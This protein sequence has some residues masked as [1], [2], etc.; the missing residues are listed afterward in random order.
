MNTYIL[1][2]GILCIVLGLIHS[3]LG[4]YLIFKHKRNKSELVPTKGGKDLREKHLRIIWATWH[5]ASIFGL[6][7]GLLLIRLSN[8]SNQMDALLLSSIFQIVTVSMFIA[9]FL[10]L[11]STKA[12][13]PGWIVLL[14]IGVLLLLGN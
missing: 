12:K 5:L 14:F 6:C 13:H 10:V 4:E 1:I 7:I 8:D 11:Y 2:A 9:S 3:L